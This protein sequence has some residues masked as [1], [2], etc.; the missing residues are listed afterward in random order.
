M[1]WT[2]LTT[3]FRRLRR[4]PTYALLNGVGLTLA[5]A[6]CLLIGLYTWEELRVNTGYEH[7]DRIMV[8]GLESPFFG[9]TTATPAP[10]APL[11][12]KRSPHVDRVARTGNAQKKPLALAG[13]RPDGQSRVLPADSSFADIFSFEAAHGT[14][15]TALDQP[16]A[17]VLTEP[18]A[19]QYF[20]E[21]N[22]VGETIR[23]G[24]GEE[25]TTRTVRAVIETPP[26][27][28]TL[29]FDVLVPL[30]EPPVRVGGGGPCMAR[31]RCSTGP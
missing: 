19:R 20:G 17:A 15:E 11:L 29:Q 1:F 23:V 14:V 26:S 30:P 10:L 13:E 31:T 25:A 16:D 3:A 7:A 5:L 18:V 6:A 28:S 12:E 2:D 9:P 22:P 27:A 21:Q 4:R 24:R 8:M